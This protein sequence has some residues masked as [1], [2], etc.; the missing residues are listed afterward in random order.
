MHHI[1][2][3]RYACIMLYNTV[4][5]TSYNITS[6]YMHQNITSLYMHHNITSLCMPIRTHPASRRPALLRQMKPRDRS[7]TAG[8]GSRRAGDGE[9]A[10]PRSWEAAV[11]SGLS[12]ELT[13]ESAVCSVLAELAL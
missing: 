10:G 8:T 9:A 1:T 5:H 7:G 2:E 11:Y 13:A 3:H 12:A 4:I 6:L